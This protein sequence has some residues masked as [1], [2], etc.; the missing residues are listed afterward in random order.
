[1]GSWKHWIA[2]CKVI[3]IPEYWMPLTIRIRNPSSTD[4]GCLLLDNLTQGELE[5]VLPT[6]TAGLTAGSVLNVQNSVKWNV[7][8]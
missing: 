3:R 5:E 7:Y 4:K 8:K 2:P 6:V 1:M